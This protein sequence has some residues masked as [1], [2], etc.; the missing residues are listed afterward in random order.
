MKEPRARKRLAN[1]REEHLKLVNEAKVKC[2]RCLEVP[3]W[4]YRGFARYKCSNCGK[5]VESK[6]FY[7]FILSMVQEKEAGRK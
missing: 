6:Y 7:K 5:N 3:T 2:P 1:S 4:Q